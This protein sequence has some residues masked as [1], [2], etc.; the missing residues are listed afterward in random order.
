VAHVEDG[1]V[2][3]AVQ[4]LLDDALGVVD[5]E[6]VACVAEE[7]PAKS[8]ILPLLATCRSFRQ[9]SLA[10]EKPRRT[11]AN[12]KLISRYITIKSQL[13]LPTTEGIFY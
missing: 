5:G 2:G 11:L 9:V 6:V 1:S 8:T 12:N 3:A 7:I 13:L 4:V 10:T